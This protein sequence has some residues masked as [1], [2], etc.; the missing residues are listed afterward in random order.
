MVSTPVDTY[1][2]CYLDVQSNQVLMVLHSSLDGHVA[3]SSSDSSSP[4]D[5]HLQSSDQWASQLKPESLRLFKAA[6]KCP[7]VADFSPGWEQRKPEAGPSLASGEYDHSSLNGNNTNDNSDSL[8]CVWSPDGTSLFALR[9]HN[10]QSAVLPAKENL[11]ADVDYG[12][13]VDG[14]FL[15]R[16][17][18]MDA[19]SFCG[20]QNEDHRDCPRCG[21]VCIR[22]F[23]ISDAVMCS[24]CFFDGA[25]ESS[26]WFCWKCGAL[27]GGLG[28]DDGHYY[29]WD[30]VLSV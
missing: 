6:S 23:T 12:I 22:E 16:Y 5:L 26:C 24:W 20:E 7:I 19:H 1:V 21:R 27:T 13:S 2:N 10:L 29:V 28:K 25:A 3:M 4:R 11:Y 14:L 8:Y 17:P 30:C 18:F 15:S 9:G